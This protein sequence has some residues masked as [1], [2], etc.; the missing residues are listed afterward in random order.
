MYSSVKP[1][2]V[3]SLALMGAPTAVLEKLVSGNEMPTALAT[4]EK[5]IGV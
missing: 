5:V 1:G 3:V 2:P 4:L